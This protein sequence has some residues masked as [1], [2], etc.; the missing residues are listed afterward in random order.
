MAVLTFGQRNICTTVDYTFG[1]Y[2]QNKS[3]AAQGRVM[4]CTTT[5]K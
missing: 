1:N 2:L 5:E 4:N 3:L